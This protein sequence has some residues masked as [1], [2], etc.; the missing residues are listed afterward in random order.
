MI[1]MHKANI[2]SRKFFR[3]L[4]WSI[5]LTIAL[6]VLFLAAIWRELRA[7]LRWLLSYWRSRCLK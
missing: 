4:V 7:I 1:G 2:Y 3:A 5:I 6:F